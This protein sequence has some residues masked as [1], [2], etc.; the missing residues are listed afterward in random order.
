M[1]EL[2]EKLASIQHV[3]VSAIVEEEKEEAKHRHYFPEWKHYFAAFAGQHLWNANSEIPSWSNLL[4]SF[5]CGFLV[6]GKA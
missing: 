1:Q 4:L 3:P 6:I 5:S 2:R